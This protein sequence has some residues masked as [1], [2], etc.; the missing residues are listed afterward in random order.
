M[1][2][3]NGSIQIKAKTTAS[4]DEETGF[5]SAPTGV[6]WGDPI[7]CQWQAVTYSALAFSN[8]ESYTRCSFTALVEMPTGLDGGEQVRLNSKGGEP[9]GDYSVERVEDLDAVC[10]WRIWLK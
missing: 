4:I 10:Q 8:G 2:I 5:Y 7:P 6:E 1:I 9:I 3:A